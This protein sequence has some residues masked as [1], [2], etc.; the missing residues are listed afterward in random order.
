MPRTRSRLAVSVAIFLFLAAPEALAT[1]QPAPAGGPIAQFSAHDTNSSQALTYSLWARILDTVIAKDGKERNQ[2][3]FAGLGPKGKEALDAFVADLTN[4]R[5]AQLNRNEQLAFWLNL[6]NA[7]SLRAMLDQF[8]SI[9]GGLELASRNPY[10]SDTQR[11]N[12]KRVYT[13]DDNPWTVRNLTVDA[14]TLSLNDIEHR[15]LYAFWK[16]ETVMYGLWCPMR[17]CPALNGAPFFG[18]QVE[19][20]LGAAAQRYVADTDIVKVKGTAAE[21]S[22]LYKF[23]LAALGGESGVLEH[24]RRNAGPRQAELAAV[25]RIA[26]YDFDWKL[27]GKVPP[28]ATQLPRGQMNR[29]AGAGGQ[30][31]D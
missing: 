26:G 6:Y 16:P 5:V 9:G 23:Q 28:P 29:G 11:F 3:D 31:Q 30:L 14:V 19:Q 27:A 7:A 25:T 8:A 18:A 22:E 20:Q 13:A 24:L 15:I 12:V 17:G 2:I 21:V 4:V 1:P 10:A